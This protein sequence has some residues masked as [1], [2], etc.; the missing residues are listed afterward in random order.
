MKLRPRLSRT[1]FVTA[2][3]GAG[4]TIAATI[5]AGPALATGSGP[6]AD[7][8]LAFYTV[9]RTS[10]P[11]IYVDVPAQMSLKI[12][13]NDGSSV[14]GTNVQ[15][16]IDK[17]LITLDGSFDTSDY[18]M[19]GASASASYDSGI[20]FG[21]W[22]ATID[23][24]NHTVLIETVN[25]SSGREGL[26][27]GDSVTVTF[28]VTP[29]VP[30]PFDI[31]V[32]AAVQ[33]DVTD[34]NHHAVQT[35]DDPTVNVGIQVNCNPNKLCGSGSASL[36]SGYQIAAGRDQTADTLR[37]H[38]NDSASMHCTS[39]TGFLAF[40][41]TVDSTGGQ[42]DRSKIV[43]LTGADNTTPACWGSDLPFYTTSDATDPT[44]S[45]AI[46][47]TGTGDQNPALGNEYEGLLPTCSDLGDYFK[48][49]GTHLKVSDYPCVDSSVTTALVI[50]APPGDPRVTG[51]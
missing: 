33:H 21:D 40:D 42:S 29:T 19:T 26:W 5:F 15:Q 10:A 31:P 27:P 43:T 34:P 49:L 12:T 39:S 1:T 50:D 13:A 38:I 35:N 3:V 32:V 6:K 9:H 36:L 23:N 45:G 16:P 7:Q 28:T 25:D 18:P 37:A 2:L 20:G 17:A 24:V 41:I 47:F 8:G 48:N 22:S 44:M 4:A 51:Y 46:R 11:V 30:G 14:G